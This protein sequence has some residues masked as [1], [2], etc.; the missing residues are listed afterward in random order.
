M[1]GYCPGA[2]DIECCV[3]TCTTPSGSGT[4]QWTS[5]TC[6]GSFIAGYCPGPDDIEC[7]ITSG[8]STSTGTGSLGIDLSGAA[9]SGFWS[10]A[11]ASYKVAVIEGYIQG[12]SIVR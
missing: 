12:C 4:C 9:P 8:S 11:A 1:A 3:A 6:N 10:C 2:A 7:C 5:S